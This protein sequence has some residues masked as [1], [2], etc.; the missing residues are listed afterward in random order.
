MKNYKKNYL[1]LILILLMLFLASC[2]AKKS[3]S[4]DRPPLLIDPLPDTSDEENEKDDVVSEDKESIEMTFDKL[5]DGAVINDQAFIDYYESLQINNELAQNAIYASVNGNGNGTID[6]PYSLEDALLEVKPGQTLYLRGGTYIPSNNEGFFISKSGT[7]S[8]YITIKNYPNEKA[9]I[10]NSSKKSSV[11]GFQIDENTQYVIME[12]LEIKNIEAPNAFGI[13]VWGNNQNHLIFKNN[14]IH[15][16]KTTSSGSSA[17]ANGILFVGENEK[18]ISNVIV[19]SNHIYNNVT[20]WAESLSVAGNCEYFYVINNVVENNTNI[21]I[22]FYGNAGYCNNPKLDQ[23]RYSIA[24]GNI[25]TKSVCDYADCAGLYVDGARDI[26]LQYNVIKESLYG[27]EIGSEERNDNYPVKNIIVR[28]NQCIDN[29]LSIRIGGYEENETGFVTS[30]KVYENKFISSYNDYQIILS[31]CD[32]IEI[33]Q[34]YFYFNVKKVINFEF[35]DTLCK[36][37]KFINN[38]LYSPNYNKDDLIFKIFS[39]S[40]SFNEFNNKYG[41]NKFEEFEIV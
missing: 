23:P 39:S 9:I 4:D 17:T 34:N 38:I 27:I 6:N 8:S 32:G 14:S 21:G 3:S 16:I 10:T 40:F 29:N 25:V 18:P 24:S 12:G 36:N 15:D 22:D 31:K 28:Y 41:L 5:I 19:A 1:F 37:I 11:Y 13:A 26:I 20:G 7:S 2:G 35:N 33:F 30:T